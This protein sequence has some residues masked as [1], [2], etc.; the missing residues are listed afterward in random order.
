MKK[1]DGIYLG[2]ILDLAEKIKQRVDQRSREEFDAD[3]DLRIVL[4][5]FVQNI[6]EAARCISPLFK[7]SHPEI[8][9]N[10]I[11]GMRHRIVHDYLDI[12]YDIVWDVAT[13]ELPKLEAKIVPLIPPL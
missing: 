5:H 8:P 1:D 7:Q 10:D 3:E 12:D 6:G 9:W 11:V 4:T 2:H 13:V